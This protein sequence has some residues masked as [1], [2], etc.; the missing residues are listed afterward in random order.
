M[1]EIGRSETISLT[2]FPGR[3]IDRRMW[4]IYL[5]LCTLSRTVQCVLAE[6][7]KYNPHITFSQTREKC[8]VLPDS[9]VC[10]SL[11]FGDLHVDSTILRAYHPYVV[12]KRMVFKSVQVHGYYLLATVCVVITVTLYE[13]QAVSNHRHIEFLFKRL[14]RIT[15]MKWELSKLLI[16]DPLVLGRYPAMT[17]HY[18]DVIMGAMASQITYRLFRRRSKKA[19]KLRVTGLFAGNSPVTVEFL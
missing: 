15:S 12:F 19:L 5:L 10:Y 11:S 3:Y 18:N 6:Y 8:F 13:L 14:L 9:Y 17:G 16:I 2:H 4:E 7:W 1:T